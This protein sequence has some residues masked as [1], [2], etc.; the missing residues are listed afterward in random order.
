[1]TTEAPALDLAE[2]DL[3]LAGA[4]ARFDHAE[5]PHEPDVLALIGAAE[6]LRKLVDKA[7]YL[8]GDGACIEGECHHLEEDETSCGLV[9]TLFATGD[10]AVRLARITD[11]LNDKT[12]EIETV[13]EARFQLDVLRGIAAGTYDDNY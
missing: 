7:S 1:M 8:Y 5:A 11:R 12:I 4:K 10:D 3:A 2:L 9:Q 13:D 6:A